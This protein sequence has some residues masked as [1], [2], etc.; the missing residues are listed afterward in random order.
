MLAE[1]AAVWS[2][3]KGPATGA[4]TTLTTLDA[5]ALE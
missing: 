2:L 3:I 5:I 1:K 4:V